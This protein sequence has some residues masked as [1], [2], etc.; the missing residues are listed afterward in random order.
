MGKGYIFTFY[1]K[2]HTISSYLPSPLL[3]DYVRSNEIE[4]NKS[5]VILQRGFYKC[6]PSCLFDQHNG[7]ILRGQCYI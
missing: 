3:K 4:M 7:T 1:N 2:S 5:W 6:R